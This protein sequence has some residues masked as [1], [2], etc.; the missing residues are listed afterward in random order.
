MDQ[1]YTI[2]LCE[3]LNINRKIQSK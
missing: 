1:M 3:I 2:H